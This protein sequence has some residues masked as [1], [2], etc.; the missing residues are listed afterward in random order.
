MGAPH[1]GW[2]IRENITKMDDSGLLPFME[3]PI[4]MI[5]QGDQPGLHLR[6][7]CFTSAPRR[8][9]NRSSNL[10]SVNHGII[11]L[12]TYGIYS[13]LPQYIVNIDRYMY[14]LYHSIK[15]KVKSDIL[16]SCNLMKHIQ[17]TPVVYSLR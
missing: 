1:S 14:I 13:K 4:W 8:N 6:L 17:E 16:E 2:F 9:A 11:T 10:G 12:D 3:I 15:G 5:N 7:S